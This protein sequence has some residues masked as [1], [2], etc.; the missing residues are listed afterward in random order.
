MLDKSDNYPGKYYA[1]NRYNDITYRYYTTGSGVAKW[2]DGWPDFD[3]TDWDVVWVF[4]TFEITET[5]Y[6]KVELGTAAAYWNSVGGLTSYDDINVM[7]EPSYD[8]TES[9]N[10]IPIVGSINETVYGLLTND[11]TRM[12]LQDTSY[13][14]NCY[15]QSRITRI[16]DAIGTNR[17]QIWQSPWPTPTITFKFNCHPYDS[18]VKLQD[19]IDYNATVA[20]ADEEKKTVPIYGG[21]PVFRAT[22][23]GEVTMKIEFMSDLNNDV[24]VG[25]SKSQFANNATYTIDSDLNLRNENDVKYTN[26]K[27]E[28]DK[29]YTF[30]MDVRKDDVIWIK[31]YD[32]NNTKGFTGA[33]TNSI[34]LVEE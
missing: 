1:V 18:N 33:K 17:K 11:L 28:H 16:E 34:I 22:G 19:L 15:A 24:Y 30:K 29:G 9:I 23:N 20:Y 27:F 14:W 32:A 21:L 4:P 25:L 3:A 13:D 7:Y 8:A 10:V 2:N 12:K 5:E 31:T 26:N 6:W